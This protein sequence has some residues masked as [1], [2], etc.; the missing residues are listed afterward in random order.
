MSNYAS[1]I[2]L[3]L[4]LLALPRIGAKTARRI[5]DSLAEDALP[6]DGGELC[7]MLES[8][9]VP[10]R[11]IPTVNCTDA[12]LA[13][14]QADRVLDGCCQH[15]IRAVPFGDSLLPMQLWSIGDPPFVMYVRGRTECLLDMPTVA[16]IGTRKPTDYGQKTGHRF[17]SRCA[18]AGV[19]VVSGLAI[20]CDTVAHKGCLDAGGHTVAVMA[21]GLDT[22]SPVRNRE[23]AAQIVD[24]G[25]CLVGE[26]PPGT[27]PRANQYV[28]RDRLQS[29][30][31]RAVI[32]VETDVKGGTMHT[33]GFAKK[34]GRLLACL[35]HP[36][37]L[38]AEAQTRGNQ[39]LIADG[40]ATPLKDA[41]D[42]QAFIER[43]KT[44]S[45]ATSGPPEDEVA[46]SMEQPTANRTLWDEAE[47]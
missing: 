9:K 3:S 17:A 43:V 10:G 46:P 47:S 33:V 29:A 34:Q 40:D 44:D 41:A 1:N 27:E 32:V 28:E 23:L 6:A 14:E 13:F 24:E 7:D 2:R 45:R 26:Y 42:L 15:E 18:D 4:A 11:A 8:I 31:S 37:H 12:T 35:D 30:L 38:L 16:I 19:T 22:V 21:H 39:K 36:D 5:F 25:G 20:G